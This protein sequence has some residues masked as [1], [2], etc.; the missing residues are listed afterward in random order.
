MKNKRLILLSN[1][2][3]LA[4]AVIAVAI[5]GLSRVPVTERADPTNQ[6]QVALGRGVYARHC[7]SCHGANLEGQPNWRERR[8]DGRLPAPPHDVTGHTWEHSDESLFKVTKQGVQAF[9]GPDYQTDMAGFG[10]VLSDDEIWAAIAYI[11]STWPLELVERRR[12][13]AN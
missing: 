9:A 5:L 4:A 1:I 8:P 6:A 7:A 3:A 13:R 2:A 10:K 11:K 12:P